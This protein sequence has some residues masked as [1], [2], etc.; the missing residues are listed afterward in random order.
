MRQHRRYK[1][2]PIEEAL[3]EF[4]FESGQDWDPTIPG[5]LHVELAEEYSGKPQEQRAMGLEWNA[6]E[7]QLNYNEGLAKVQLVTDDGRR[8]V[9]V[10]PDV[11][12][13]HVLRPYHNPHFLDNS[14]WGEFK[15]RIGRALDAYWKVVRPAGVYRVGIRYINKIIIPQSVVAIGEYFRCALPQVGGLPTCL[16]ASVSRAEY[17][18]PDDIRLILTQGSIETPED[19]Y[20]YLLDIDLI[21]ERRE[22]VSQDEAMTQASD[23]RT[24]EREVFESVITDKARELFN[25]S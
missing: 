20:G 5:K 2:P 22:P 8:M 23:L 9:G 24:R 17:I 18:Y 6:Q 13:V 14:G 12:S 16:T 21:G 11:L 19:Q 25:A 15:Q 3:C 10:G 1:N 7:R 4:R